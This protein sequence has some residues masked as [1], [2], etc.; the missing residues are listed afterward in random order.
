MGIMVSDL[1]GVRFNYL[2]ARAELAVIQGRVHNLLYSRTAQRLSPEQRSETRFHIEIL[3]SN[4]RSSIPQ[5][6]MTSDGIFRRLSHTPIHLMM[7]MYNRH[8]E[9]L[10]RIHGVFAFDETWIDRVRC[11][12]S[13]SCIEISDDGMDGE[14]NHREISPLPDDW[15]NCV[16]HSRLGLELSAFGRETEYSV[17]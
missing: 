8:L 10:Y 11:Y 17:W 15:S 12:L 6:L 14:I 1:G 2:R 13:P 3:L 9:C 16:Q 5:A 4:W 7:N